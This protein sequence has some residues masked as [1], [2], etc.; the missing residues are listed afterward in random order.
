MD[1]FTVPKQDAKAASFLVQALSVVSKFALLEDL[2]TR[3]K[4]QFQ[5][6]L[7][8]D[9]FVSTYK[10]RPLFRRHLRMSYESFQTIV[11]LV[12]EK[13]DADERVVFRHLCVL[14]YFRSVFLLD[15]LVDYSC[16]KQYI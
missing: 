15:C 8:W 11:E 16:H 9:T 1:F 3:Q 13:I 14:W 7:D 12:K 6:R 4:S 5:Q 2:E 10:N